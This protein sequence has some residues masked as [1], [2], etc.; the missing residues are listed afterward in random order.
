MDVRGRGLSGSGGRRAS[1]REAILEAETPVRLLG[2]SAKAALWAF[3]S[4]RR[5]P[6]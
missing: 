4:S 6:R 3:A 5:S 2:A 1:N